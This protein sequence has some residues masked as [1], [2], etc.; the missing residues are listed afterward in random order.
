[1]VLSRLPSLIETQVLPQQTVPTKV[2]QHGAAGEISGESQVL[3]SG[4]QQ[5]QVRLAFS[6]RG[7]NHLESVGMAEVSSSSSEPETVNV[8]QPFQPR[9]L[10]RSIGVDGGCVRTGQF[11]LWVLV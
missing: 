4:R 5:L 11:L 9:I 7:K 10:A 8:A 2:R 6:T 1:M 3:L